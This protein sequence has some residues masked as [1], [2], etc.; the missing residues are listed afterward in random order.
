[1]KICWESMKA[2]DKVALESA[3]EKLDQYFD[4][5]KDA[6]MGAVSDRAHDGWVDSAVRTVVECVSSIV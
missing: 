5:W 6:A 3:I 1:M 2:N 4:G